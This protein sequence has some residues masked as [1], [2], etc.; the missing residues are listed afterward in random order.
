MEA[1]SGQDRGGTSGPPRVDWRLSTGCWANPASALGSE[2]GVQEGRRPPGVTGVPRGE[3]R[4]TGSQ[5]AG[6]PLP[7]LRP[8]GCP[9][10]PLATPSPHP[11][12]PAGHPPLVHPCRLPLPPD[13]VCLLQSRGSEL[14]SQGLSVWGSSGASLSPPSLHTQSGVCISGLCPPSAPSC[15]DS[16]VL[17]N[18]P[19]LRKQPQPPLHPAHPPL[20]RQLRLRSHRS[21][22]SYPSGLWRLDV[23]GQGAGRFR[24]WGV[25]SY[26][27]HPHPGGGERPPVLRRTLIPRWPPTS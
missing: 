15:L 3:M 2:V 9:P 20:L 14:Q 18:V 12:P 23:Q 10:S 6:R 21:R 26:R 7:H 11:D 19:G 16:H 8:A 17:R 24:S 13:F 4:H 5:A 1:G 25:L 22:V 27:Q